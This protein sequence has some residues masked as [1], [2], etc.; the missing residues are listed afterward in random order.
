MPELVDKETAPAKVWLN[1]MDGADIPAV[2]D[3]MPARL[4]CHTV[5]DVFRG[6]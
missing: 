4:D 2:D 1:I 3:R 6:V 5:G